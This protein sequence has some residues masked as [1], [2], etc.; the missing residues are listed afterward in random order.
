[1]Y[2]HRILFVSD[3]LIAC[4]ST[5]SET[6]GLIGRFVPLRNTLDSDALK[7][8]IKGISACFSSTTDFVVRS[9]YLFR[10]H[11]NADGSFTTQLIEP[12]AVA[13]A[14][15]CLG[16][17]T[18]AIQEPD[19][20]AALYDTVRIKQEEV[21]FTIGDALSTVAGGW[22]SLS[23]ADPLIVLKGTQCFTNQL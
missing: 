21:H 15:L 7:E 1:M 5:V 13:L 14:N 18:L 12:A 4:Q 9:V 23:A 11:L 22:S 6:L 19:L 16:D 17:R 8:T 20:L 10:L 3:S 2:Y